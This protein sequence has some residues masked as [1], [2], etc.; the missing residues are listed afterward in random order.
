[1]AIKK[2]VKK[3][4]KKPIKKAKKQHGKIIKAKQ[5]K[6]VRKKTA[7]PAAKKR[8]PAT[9]RLHQAKAKKAVPVMAKKL[10]ASR[11]RPVKGKESQE[12]KKEAL[13]K[14]LIQTREQF[15]REA[16]IEISKYIRGE[17]RQLVDTALDDGDWSIVDLSEDVSLRKLSTHRETLVK[18]DE[19]LRKLDEGTYGTCESCGEE[20]SEQ[21][22]KVMPFAIYCKDCQE[23]IEQLEAIENQV[24]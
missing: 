8:K 24:R 6:A 7:S 13:R 2:L 3:A 12:E 11:L 15:V 22:L 23:R 10:V 19:S 21:R 9:G 18:I 14:L 16:K 17:T 1:M 4:I 20:I 5:K